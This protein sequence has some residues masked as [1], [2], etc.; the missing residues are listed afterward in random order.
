MIDK[1]E[2]CIACV[3]CGGKTLSM[4]QGFEIEVDEQEDSGDKWNRIEIR[5]ALDHPG[6]GWELESF[7]LTCENCHGHDFKV[8]YQEVLQK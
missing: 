3:K 5:R 1:R 4:A 8:Q 7:T 2:Y 6:F